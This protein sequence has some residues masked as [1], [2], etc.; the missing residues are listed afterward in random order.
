MVSEGGCQSV[1]RPKM[2]GK[3][4]YS[5]RVGLICGREGVCMDVKVGN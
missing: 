2:D 1:V 3:G 4:V 5:K